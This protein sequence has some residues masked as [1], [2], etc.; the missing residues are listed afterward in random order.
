M[1]KKKKVYWIMGVFAFLFVFMEIFLRVFY[2]EELAVKLNAEDIFENDSVLLYTYKPNY[3]FNVADR[4][5]SVNQDGYLGEDFIP[6]KDS[7][8]RIALV[9]ACGVAGS[10]HQSEYYNYADELQKLFNDNNYNVR[11]LNCGIDG[12][13]RTLEHYLSIEYK[14]TAFEPDIILL[15][16]GLPLY[17]QNAKRENY[18]DYKISYPKTDPASRERLRLMVDTL[19]QN[20]WWI[21]PIIKSY[22]ARS[23]FHVYKNCSSKRLGYYIFMY[24]Q[25]SFSI[26]KWKPLTY[27]M[28]E[29]ANMIDSLKNRLL[30]QG[31][32][33]FLL[34]YSVNPEAYTFSKE[35]RLPLI[36]LNIEFNKDDYFVSDMHWNGVGSK[37]IADRLFDLIVKHHLVPEKYSVP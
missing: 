12:H 19:Y 1:A 10:V 26:G 9:G 17:S 20:E 14:V 28:E 21:K 27:T 8:F 13:G 32:K 5:L 7:A 4:K 30:A 24:K 29:S 36:S 23:V 34:E 3:I 25:K 37:K 35:R 15:E 2:K 16:Y 18:R 6:K 31:I 22:I 33:L 11:V